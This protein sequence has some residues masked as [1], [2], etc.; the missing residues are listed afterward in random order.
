VLATF[1]TTNLNGLF[2]SWPDGLP[3]AKAPAYIIFPAACSSVKPCVRT[4]LHQKPLVRLASCI[5][6]LDMCSSACCA[7]FWTDAASTLMCA[8]HVPVAEVRL[9]I[10]KREAA[11]HAV[12]IEWLVYPCAKDF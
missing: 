4:Y 10:R 8:Q 6:V 3:V 12:T 1:L 9:A 11:D 2:N 5:T 7:S